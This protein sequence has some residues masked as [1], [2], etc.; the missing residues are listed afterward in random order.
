MSMNP[1]GWFEIYVDDMARA[2]EFYQTVLAIT[3][4]RLPSPTG[5][6]L[7]M[8]SFASNM[9]NYG[10]SGALVKMDGISAGGNSTLVY[11]SC[12]DCAVEAE[13]VAAAGGEVQQGKMAIGDYGFI[14]IITDSEGNTVGLHSRA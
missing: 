7:E 11:F 3:L 1:V 8:Y 4:D 14:A 2:R 6:E 12:Q 9:E 5:S 13:R 10:S